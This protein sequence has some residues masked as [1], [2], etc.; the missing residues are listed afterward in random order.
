MTLNRSSRRRGRLLSRNVRLTALCLTALLAAGCATSPE[1]PPAPAATTRVH[2]DTPAPARAP[3]IA[4]DDEFAI[5]A[6]GEGDDLQ[7]LAHHYLGSADL[8]WRI[9]ELND[10]ERVQRGQTVVIPLR[11][12]NAVGVHANGY[13]TVPILCYHR[14]GPKATKLTVTK[15]AFE[16]QMEYLARNGYHVVPLAQLRRF[17]QA[18]E[19]LPRK[20]VAI[21]IDD[22]YRSAFEVAYPVLR[23]HGFPATVFL[24]SDFVGAPDALTWPQMKEMIASGLVE[25]QPHSKSHSKLTQKQPDESDARYRERIRREVETPVNLIRDRLDLSSATFA[26]PYGDVNETV[27]SELE[28]SGVPVGVTVTPGGNGFFAHPYMLR[29]SMIF[30]N[31]D[32]AAFKAKLATFTRVGNR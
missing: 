31:E 7:A 32:L 12:R 4:R 9:A 10:I 5:V 6:V 2:K 15:A 28:R 14:F 1:L 16:A 23:K 3:L 20:T 11:E 8:A 25:V 27:V 24:Y 21:S 13:Q 29:R 19:P 17:L 26:Y 18:K 30:G 22:G